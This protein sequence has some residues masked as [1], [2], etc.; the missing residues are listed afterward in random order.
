MP[1]VEFDK[2]PQVN[3]GGTDVDSGNIYF[4]MDVCGK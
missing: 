3:D 4:E 2:V 1:W